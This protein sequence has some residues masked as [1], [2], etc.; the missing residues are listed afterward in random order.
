M[1]LS[2]KY[3]ALGLFAL[4]TTTTIQ[5]SKSAGEEEQKLESEEQE[6]RKLLKLP[7]PA[8]DTTPAPETT[9]AAEKIKATIRKYAPIFT[10]AIGYGVIQNLGFHYL[11]KKLYPNS[12]LPFLVGIVGGTII[13]EID[14][15][16]FK[17]LVKYFFAD[18]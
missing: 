18:C 3:L 4:F 8:S 14:R 13:S 9:S 1:K 5:T 7:T 11:A 17:Q 6:L 10:C 2:T 15:I 16:I 12:E